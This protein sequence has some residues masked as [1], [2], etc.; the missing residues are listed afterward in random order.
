MAA[1]KSSK[2]GV[3]DSAF[4][5]NTANIGGVSIV[6]QTTLSGYTVDSAAAKFGHTIGG[7]TLVING[8]VFHNN[9]ANFGSVLYV[10]G[11]TAK[12]ADSFLHWNTA[13]FSGG[14]INANTN[15]TVTLKM[16]NVS[17]NRA[18]K[19]GGVMSLTDQSEA[20]IECCTFSSNIAQTKGGVFNIQESNILISNSTFGSSS[21]A[22]GDG[23]AIYASNSSLQIETS[24]FL[25][26]RVS[27]NG[28][29]V[30]VESNTTL[31]T[32]CCNFTK[33]T[34]KNNGGA[35]FLNNNSQGTIVFSILQ[36]NMADNGG[37]LAALSNSFI[38]IKNCCSIAII[39]HH[40][41]TITQIQSNNAGTSGGGIYLFQSSL[42]FR[43]QINIYYNQA[44]KSG[45]GIHAV[46]SSIEFQS[47]I[48]LE[49]NRAGY[50]GG[51]SLT[52]SD[53]HA[54][55]HFQSAVR[56]A[57]NEA[58][59]GGALYV[60]DSY[61]CS[62]DHKWQNTYGCFF[63]NVSKHFVIS[64]NNNSANDT[65]NDLYGGQLD[66]CSIDSDMNNTE[67]SLTYWKV[68]SNLTDLTTVSSQPARVC[69]CK[70]FEP[71]CDER[72]SSIQIRQG[73]KFQISVVVV[74]QVKQ[75]IKSLVLSTVD[76]TDAAFSQTRVFHWSNV[77][78]YDLEYNIS[79]PTAGET[80]ELMIDVGNT[81]CKDTAFSKIT[82]LVSV[83]NCSCAPGF[84]SA[85]I[86]GVCYCICDKQDTIFSKYIQK[87]FYEDLTVIREG[88]FWITYLNDSDHSGY[89]FFPY[90][91]LEY[92]QP[93]GVPVPV[94][95]SQPNGSDAQCIDNR[96]G[97]LCGSCP[98]NY[99]LSL[100]SAKCLVCPD[101]W[102]GLLI[103]IVLA[104]FFAGIVLVLLLLVFNLTVAV[105]TLNSF[106]FYAN[107]IYANKN[108]YFGH[109]HFMLIQ[110][111][112]SWLN[113]DIGFEA[114]FF[115]GLDTYAKTWLQLAFPLYIIALIILII[116]VSS[117]SSKFSHLIGRKDPVATLATLI[118]L[119]YTKLLQMVIASSSYVKEEYPDGTSTIRWVRDA[120][121]EF[122]TG[123]SIALICVAL[124]ILIIGLLYT[125]FVL[126]WQCLVKCPRSRLFCWTRNHKLYSFINTYHTPHNA[127]HRYWPG[128]LLL[129]RVTVYLIAAF[130]ASSDQPITLLS[131]IVIMCCLLFYKAHSGIRVYRNWLLNAIES[132]VHFNITVFAVFTMFTFI[133]STI[134][135]GNKE[136][137]QRVVANLSIGSVVLLI[138]LVIIYHVYRYGSAKVYTFVNSMSL[139]S[140][141][142]T[143]NQ[144]QNDWKQL[145]NPLL[146][147]I[148]ER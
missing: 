90:C 1:Y 72:A 119:S 42:S 125:F 77:S 48:Q 114:C 13:R 112:T 143:Y 92:C 93:P 57:F 133:S 71:H 73:E 19:R 131:T 117:C 35:L 89:L 110:V 38:H 94:N 61:F 29:A 82:V 4:I 59:L 75:P 62:G 31:M 147:V 101:N 63:R 45:G 5:E 141:L 127:K 56:F 7:S 66:R 20:T 145:D 28:G 99:S 80:Y 81:S 88:V 58:L 85:G 135:P 87:C 106:I 30:H 17:H 51:V 132:F 139:C 86:R 60:D 137:L 142:K 84:M 96:V 67:D 32:V 78:C 10:Q 3:I 8:S 16:N 108:I 40:N 138:L 144:N 2:L 11:S 14:A 120:N 34:A 49:N 136:I 65:G 146:E 113:L 23:G 39:N 70:N 124:I 25:E 76:Q 24:S 148:D 27:S 68:I 103:V 12:I 15:S 26:N 79:F 55:E 37:A 52:H 122:G 109:S 104:A 107:I 130:S 33:N 105:G 9:S 50:G 46:K 43:A 22:E 98:Q 69:H 118:L 54:D 47:S 95:L 36:H 64:F 97:L 123:K 111:I 44:E 91:P 100:G 129:I 134:G 126:F 21:V 140:L 102:H 83:I 18:K 6:F 115:D 74:D 116:V 121:I 53:W 128:L 41:N